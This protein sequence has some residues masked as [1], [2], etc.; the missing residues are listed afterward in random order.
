MLT[1]KRAKKTDAPKLCV[2]VFSHNHGTDAMV[3]AVPGDWTEGQCVK[4]VR[5]ELEA[6]YGKEDIQRDT[7][8]YGGVD[9][10]HW[11]HDGDGLTIE[12]HGTERRF[13]VRIEECT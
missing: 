10:H 5:R 1:I 2:C 11:I 6:E 9:F 8:N 12:D 3:Y 7:D 13:R 4:A